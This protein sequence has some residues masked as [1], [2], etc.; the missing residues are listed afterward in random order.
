[1]ENMQQHPNR[2]QRGGWLILLLAVLSGAAAAVFPAALVIAPALWAY[3]GAR[4]KSYWIAL[5]GAV[6]AGVAFYSYTPVSAAGLSGAA[7]LAGIL[8]YALLT[9]RVSN[10]YTALTLAGVFLAGLYVSVCLPGILEGRGAF[11]DVQAAIGSLFDVY[12]AAIAQI[13]NADAQAVQLVLELLDA[14]IK[15]VPDFVV[16]ALCIFAGTL[17][18]GNLLFFRLFCRKHPEIEISRMRAFRDWTLPRSMALGLFALLIGSLIL[19]WTDWAFSQSMTNTVNA[20]VG[21]PLLLQGLCVVDF[22]IARSPKNV[23]V[24]RALAYAGIGILFGL[25]QTP[26]ILIGCFDQVFR[27]RDRMRGAPPRAAI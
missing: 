2:D 7:I 26:L 18:L 15:A 24:G 17:G 3:A 8:V 11:A 16:S 20:L 21:M 5:P 6:F 9:R 27:I 22:L 19:E 10:T 1:M 23:N 14:N 13:P 25:A 4:T 12:R